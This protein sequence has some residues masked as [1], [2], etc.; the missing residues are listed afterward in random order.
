MFI[1]FIYGYNN[2]KL[3]AIEVCEIIEKD[4][5]DNSRFFEYSIYAIWDLLSVELIIL[6]NDNKLVKNYINENF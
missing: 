4:Y 6:N 5:Y 1:S 3:R 2:A